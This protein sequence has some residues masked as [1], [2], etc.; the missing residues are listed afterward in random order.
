[1]F[2]DPRLCST[3][4]FFIWNLRDSWLRMSDKAVQDLADWKQGCSCQTIFRNRVTCILGN[5]IGG[6]KYW[7]THSILGKCIN[8]RSL[9]YSSTN[10]MQD[11]SL[12]RLDRYFLSNSFQGQH[13]KTHSLRRPES[14]ADVAFGYSHN[15]SVAYSVNQSFFIDRNNTPHK[16]RRHI[17]TRSK[18]DQK[19]TSVVVTVVLVFLLTYLPL[20]VVRTV[21]I[22]IFIAGNTVSVKCHVLNSF[23]DIFSFT[24]IFVH[25]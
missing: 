7:N 13:Q 5:Y 17:N 9:F 6:S 25:F 11:W 10:I 8:K 15:Q 21:R 14:I 3:F 19:V 20:F 2:V 23:N 22:I 1:M 12:T 24:Q 18:Q 4:T 16:L